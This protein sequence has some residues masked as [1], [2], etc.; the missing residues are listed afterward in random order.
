M[1]ELVS[2]TL[3]IG[4]VSPEYIEHQIEVFFQPSEVDIMGKLNGTLRRLVNPVDGVVYLLLVFVGEELKLVT[5]D[6]DG[7]VVGIQDGIRVLFLHD[8]R[9]V[10]NL[11]LVKSVFRTEDESTSAVVK[12]EE[13]GILVF[14]SFHSLE[15]DLRLVVAVRILN[16]RQ[17]VTES[18]VKL[19][20]ERSLHLSGE[21]GMGVGEYV[22]V[23]VQ[24]QEAIEAVTITDDS[25]L[26][27]NSVFSV[28][29]DSH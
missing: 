20:S 2:S 6:L 25:A 17:L 18:L 4:G 21:I 1:V 3:V 7:T 5:Q 12:V 9:E 10:E 22:N 24:L 13:L 19:E 16:R 27:T 29:L 11:A 26:D 14:L 23:Q 8:G 28:S 15:I